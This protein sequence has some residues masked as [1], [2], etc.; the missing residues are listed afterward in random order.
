MLH[1]RAT[2]REDTPF[3]RHCRALPVPEGLARKMEIFRSSGQIFRDGDELFTEVGWLQ[4]MVGQGV[5]PRR[6]HALA[7]ALPGEQLDEFLGSMRTLIQ[8]AV[9]GMPAHEDYVMSQ[10]RAME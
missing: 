9:A 6:Y 4:V 10:C 8:R 2:E 1:Y 3:W 7:D 5:E